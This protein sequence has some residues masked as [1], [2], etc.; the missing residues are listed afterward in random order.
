MNYKSETIA[1]YDAYPDRFD[2][3]FEQHM[4]RHNSEHIRRFLAALRG[5]RVLDLGSGPGNHAAAFVHAGCDVLC[6]DLSVAMIEQCRKKGLEAEVLD[7]ETFELGRRFNGVWANACLLHLPKKQIPGVL[8]RIRRHLEPT[9][10]FACGVKEG[11]G[12]RF[13]SDVDYPDTQRFFSRYTDEEFR[14]LLA[15][16]FLVEHFERTS[17]PSGR[18]V[19]LK[20]LAHPRHS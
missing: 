5:P 6:G 8:D 2:Q 16:T 19:F 13:E 18:T 4:L 7:L 10:V 11:E 17:S 20:Y 15:P 14:A 9:G 12:E 3:E 1:A